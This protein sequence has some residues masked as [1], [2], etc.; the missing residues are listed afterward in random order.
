M[1][2]NRLARTAIFL[3]AFLAGTVIAASVIANKAADCEASASASAE[4]FLNERGAMLLDERCMHKGVP[5]L[6]GL[7]GG[8]MRAPDGEGCVFLPRSLMGP[9]ASASAGAGAGAGA[10]ASGVESASGR[11]LIA[12]RLGR[13]AEGPYMDG[14]IFESAEMRGD[15]VCRVKLSRDASA[16][17]VRRYN[18]AVVERRRNMLGVVPRDQLEKQFLLQQARNRAIQTAV[19]GAETAASSS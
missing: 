1:A 10:G 6:D 7:N 8:L 14:S 2:R 19:V 17:A 9:G 4:P 13:G 15:G 16:D 5:V 3:L 11:R 18:E 12:C